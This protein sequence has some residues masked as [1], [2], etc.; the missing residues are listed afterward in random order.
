MLATNLA[1]RPFDAGCL[2]LGLH[3]IATAFYSDYFQFMNNKKHFFKASNAGFVLSAVVLAALIECAGN[4]NGQNAK[5]NVGINVAPPV[6]VAPPIVVTP[7]VMQDNYVYYPSYGV[8]YNSSRHQYAYQDRGMWVSRPSPSGVSADMLRAS[9]SVKMDF[10]DSP[11][12]H[13]AAM[14]QKY[15]KNWAP[16]S[17][18]HGKQ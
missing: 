5:V 18:G 14:V 6:V 7:P 11:E 10:H 13:H 4:A 8:Y 15:P 16:P 9:P 2:Y 17:S 3:P 1:I 12:K